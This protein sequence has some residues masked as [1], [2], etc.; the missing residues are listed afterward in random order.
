[1]PEGQSI[2][3]LETSLLIWHYSP[4]MEVGVDSD[5]LAKAVVLFK[6]IRNIASYRQ[7]VGRIGRENDLEILIQVW[8]H[9]VQ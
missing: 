3:N 6:A 8:H 2:L 4:A 7:K 5:N 9:S 1:M